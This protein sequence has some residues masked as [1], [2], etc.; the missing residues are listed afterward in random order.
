VNKG[1]KPAKKIGARLSAIDIFLAF[2]SVLIMANLVFGPINVKLFG[3]TVKIFENYLLLIIWLVSVFLKSR[4]EKQEKLFNIKTFFSRYGYEI[5]L[6]V[7]LLIVAIPRFLSIGYGLP[8]LIEPHEQ[9]IVPKVLKMIRSGTLNHGI[10]DYGSLYFIFLY[11]VFI[12]AGFISGITGAKA[13]S[14]YDIDPSFFY[15]T[16]R[17]ANVFLSIV[18]VYLVYLIGKRLADKKTALGAAAIVGIGTVHFLNSITARL[19][20]LVLVFVLLAFYYMFKLTATDKIADYCLAGLFCGFAVGTKFY[21]I[22]ISAALLYAHLMNRKRKTFSNRK[23][24]ISLLVMIFAYLITNPYIITDTDSFIRDTSRLSREL[25]VKEHWSTAKSAPEAVYAR[26]IFYDGLGFVGTAVLLLMLF[27]Y[28]RKPNSKSGFLLIFPVLHF[29]VLA[30]S[31]YV[32]HR[33]ILIAIPFL[34][35]FL[36]YELGKRI[37]SRNEKIKFNTKIVFWAIIFLISV[38]PALK[39]CRIARQYNLPITSQSA[40]KWIEANIPAGSRLLVTPYTVSLDEKLY[41]IAPLGIKSTKFPQSIFSQPETGYN[42]IITAIHAKKYGLLQEANNY[43]EIMKII[44]PVKGKMVGPT[45][46]ILKIRS[47]P[48]NLLKKSDRIF[49]KSGKKEASVMIGEPESDTIHLGSD[50]GE[51]IEDSKRVYRQARKYPA[52]FFFKISKDVRR[53]N[54]IYISVEC[55]TPVYGLFERNGH[56]F[57]ISLNGAKA[58]SFPMNATDDPAVYKCLLPVEK[59]KFGKKINRLELDVSDPHEKIEYNG[60]QVISIVP[61][62]YYSVKFSGK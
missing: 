34:V 16:A 11:F 45:I 14:I 20:L 1:R 35:L 13:I 24:L 38:F 10:Y 39:M 30:R 31:R 8:H 43:L 56:S 58:C 28:L 57:E 60:R 32:F 29:L 23:L 42:Y 18:S 12:I 41:A 52:A 53:N 47:A 33:Y 4:I 50:W 15:F 19:E 17:A 54:E 37:E 59:L 6:S 25:G 40:V 7:V 22:T 5:G 26:I 36:V 3:G 9:L 48:S 21:S 61:I 55:S 62:K 2:V 27:F 51:A 49:L 46:T 44:K